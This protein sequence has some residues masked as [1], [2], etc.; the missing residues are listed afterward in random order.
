MDS[1]D[2]HRVRKRFENTAVFGEVAGVVAGTFLAL[3]LF[4]YLPLLWPAFSEYA[5]AF[6]AAAFIYLPAFVVWRRGQGLDS[7]AVAWPGRRSWISVVLILAIVFPLFAGG[8]FSYHALLHDRRPCVEMVRLA[9]WP[10]ELR[11]GGEMG[12]QPGLYA[13]VRGEGLLV[14]NGGDLPG[15]VSWSPDAR[16]QR[17]SGTL[18]AVDGAAAVD[19][20][21]SGHRAQLQPGSW[22]H[23]VPPPGPATITITADSV[24]QIMLP[25]R[26]TAP[27]P[28]EAVRGYT[29]L[30]LLVF[31]Q[32]ILIALPEEILFRGYLQT[33]LQQL[34]P[35]RWRLWGGDLGP[36][37]ILTSVIFA[38][39]HLVA[40]PSGDRLAVFFPSLLF[41]W[42]RDRTGSIAGAVV[43][44]ALSNVL[45]QVL[46]RWVC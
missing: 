36:A 18:N 12:E 3:G 8:F 31:V 4:S 1:L 26:R 42:L 43:A 27:L 33:R 23:V 11:Q 41:G 25:L 16:I 17:S 39:S 22:V 45:M 30:L 38:L 19:G 10:E 24:T 9:D 32:F 44:H 2:T 15:A 40:I 7:I 20:V 21:Q 46:L 29:W 28:Y 5:A 6:V 34:L 13:E 14:T 35:Q 37:V